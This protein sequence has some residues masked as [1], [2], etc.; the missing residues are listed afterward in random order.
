MES[1]VTT[2]WWLLVGAMLA[3]AAWMWWNHR[4]GEVDTAPAPPLG[5]I[6]MD[7]TRKAL[8][9]LHRE[10]ARFVQTYGPEHTPG[11]PAQQ[12]LDAFTRAESIHTVYGQALQLLE[13]A[14][15]HMT[16]FL[17]VTSEPFETIAPWT[18]ARSLLEAAALAAWLMEPEL[19]AR[20]RVTRSFALRYEGL[21][22]QGRYAR[23][24]QDLDPQ[25]A[26]DR[27][28]K[29]TDIAGDLGIPPVNDRNGRQ[30]GIGE[31]MPSVTELIG[32]VLRQEEMYRLLSAVAHGHFWA[33]HQAG[34]T[35]AAEPSTASTGVRLT[36]MTKAVNPTGIAYLAV[37]CTEAFARAA[38]Y[39]C[40]YAGWKKE[41]CAE[42]LTNVF[43]SIGLAADRRAWLSV[44][45]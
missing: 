39:Q 29:V 1:E 43:D 35:V 12:D 28:A 3:S 42:I 31:R 6:E 11:S 41:E 45:G 33:T 16:A 7:V 34:F 13:I 32:E 10:S 26:L 9:Q 38:W 5:Q 40:L 37:G 22:Q 19:S 18:C 30:I 21:V 4:S 2:V 27:I 25:S 14:A 23:V 15:D 36:P 17:K 24:T 44:A 8:A 20:D